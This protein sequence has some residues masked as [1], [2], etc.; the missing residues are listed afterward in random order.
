MQRGRLLIII[1]FG[2]SLLGGLACDFGSSAELQAARAELSEAREELARSNVHLNEAVAELRSARTELAWATEVAQAQAREARGLAHSVGTL[3]DGGADGL[4]GLSRAADALNRCVDEPCRVDR[5][6]VR[7]VFEKPDELARQARVIPVV[8]D[9]VGG[10][11]GIKLFAIRSGSI[12]KLFGLK[13]GDMLTAVNGASLESFD[14]AL[15][16]YTAHKDDDKFVINIV[17]KGL[18]LILT[19]ELVAGVEVPRAD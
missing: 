15:I 18:P 14:E 16:A 4:S 8:K 19:V 11:G 3:D 6:F 13:N 7:S 17:R 5:A 1:A 10:V 2:S 9:G 12:P